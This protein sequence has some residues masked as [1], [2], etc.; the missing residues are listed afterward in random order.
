MAH[1][2]ESLYVINLNHQPS[3]VDATHMAHDCDA[4]FMQLLQP[5]PGDFLLQAHALSQNACIQ[6]AQGLLLQQSKV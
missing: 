2:Q 3:L 4:F 5:P 1:R 6:Q